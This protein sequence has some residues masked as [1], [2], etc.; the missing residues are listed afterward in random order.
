MGVAQE[1]ELICKTLG[2]KP[3]T[4]K[5]NRNVV[6]QTFFKI[7]FI[8]INLADYKSEKYFHVTTMMRK[9]I[10]YFH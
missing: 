7:S 6:I 1:V 8:K 9:S 10:I 4:L 2:S 3:S 5:I